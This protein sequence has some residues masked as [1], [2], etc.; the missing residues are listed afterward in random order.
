[1]PHGF[2]SG[3]DLS[4]GVLKPSGLPRV[5]RAMGALIMLDLM[6]LATGAAFLY[7]CVLYALACDHL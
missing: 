6:Y 2:Y 7:A 4:A 1:M 5:R 3:T